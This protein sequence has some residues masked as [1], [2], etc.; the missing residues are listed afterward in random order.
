MTRKFTIRRP[1]VLYCFQDHKVESFTRVA[2]EPALDG[3]SKFLVEKK[4]RSS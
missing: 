1:A 2:A 3:E 4:K